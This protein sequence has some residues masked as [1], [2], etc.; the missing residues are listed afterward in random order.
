MSEVL[1][2]QG[3]TKQFLLDAGGLVTNH[4][5]LS[6]EILIVPLPLDNWRYLTRGFNQSALLAK[7]LAKKLKLIYTPGVLWRTSVFSPSQTT[8]T[9]ERRRE[10][11]GGRFVVPTWKSRVLRNK[12]VIL[13]DDVTTTG[14]TLL[15]AGRILK[16]AGARQVWCLAVAQQ[17]KNRK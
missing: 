16:R 9:R 14:A 4:V 6:S 15:E 5:L 3:I 10:N 11:V 2:E 8:L 17:L 13:L 7:S 12:D 1:I